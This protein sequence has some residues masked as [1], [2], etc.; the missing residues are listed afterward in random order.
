MGFVP[1]KPRKGKERGASETVGI[2]FL[3]FN[4]VGISLRRKGIYKGQAASGTLD[5]GSYYLTTWKSGFR[6]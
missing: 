1:K 2:C 5:V 6:Y 4:Q 3:F